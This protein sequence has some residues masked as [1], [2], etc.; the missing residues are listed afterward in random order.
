MH[1]NTVYSVC[2]NCHTEPTPFIKYTLLL[3][4]HS[5]NNINAKNFFLLSLPTIFKQSTTTYCYLHVILLSLL[6]QII[7]NILSDFYFILFYNLQLKVIFLRPFKS[8]YTFHCYGAYIVGNTSRNDT[9][10]RSVWVPPTHCSSLE[11][12]ITCGFFFF[13]IVGIYRCLYIRFF[14]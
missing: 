4:Y 1:T 9:G 10:R 11:K 7:L 8:F 6:S 2:I 13:I 14:F 3:F 5:K 12:S